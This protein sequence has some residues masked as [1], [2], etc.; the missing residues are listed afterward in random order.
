M[1]PAVYRRLIKPAHARMVQAARDFGKPV[2]FHTCGAVSTLMPD[3][4]EIGLSAV[5][6]VQ[7]SA[8]DMDPVR[9]KRDFGR[10]I[11]FWG[12]VDTQRVLPLGTPAEVREEVRRRIGDLGAGGGYVL[13]AVH[14]IQAEVPAENVLAMVD[15]AHALGRY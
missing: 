10:D 14:N 11:A 4:I 6:P 15:A 12:G 3:F 8:R 5:H 1:S 13:G 2:L 7:V 9:L